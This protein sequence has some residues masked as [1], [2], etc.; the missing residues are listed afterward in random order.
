MAIAWPEGKRFAFTIFDDPD[1]QTVATGRPVYDLLADLGFRTT[2]A[3]WP[4]RGGGIPSDRGETCSEEPY[5]K[6]VETLQERGF[7]IGFHNATSHSST[8]EETGRGL[9]AFEKYFGAF[10][11][12]MSNHY[13]CAEAIYFGDRRLSGWRRGLYNLATR[14]R[15]RHFRGERPGD[16]LFWGDLCQARVRYV[17]NFVFRDVNTLAACP[18]M[19]YHDPARPFVTYWFAASQGDHLEGFVER[20]SEA[21][22]DRLEAAGGACLM[23]AHFGHGFAEHGRLD[24]RFA[25]LMERLA[26]KGGWF[27][28][29]STLLDHLLAHRPDPVITD[30][31]RATLERRWLFQ[32][33]RY[34]NA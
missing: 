11:A 4:V 5:R 8:R 9:E 16:P 13:N 29:V 22:Q 30:A 23:F 2:K 18:W 24:R 19:P 28:P 12:S 1:A 14:G 15:N 6:W 31:Q 33:L 27:V 32:K 20:L 34:G 7:E 3:V 25:R 21:N 17:R 10:P 26:R